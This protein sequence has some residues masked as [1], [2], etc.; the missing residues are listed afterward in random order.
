M[1]LQAISDLKNKIILGDNL[2]ILKQIENDTFDL[3]ITS[4]PYFQ[5]RN[6]GNSNGSS[7]LNMI[8]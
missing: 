5:Q 3:I 2:S 4:P 7:R 8:N 6:Y 1:K